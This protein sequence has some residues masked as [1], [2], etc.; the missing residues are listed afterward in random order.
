[1]TR[2]NDA[3]SVGKQ[4]IP[5]IA[6]MQ[7]HSGRMI[8]EESIVY[9]ILDLLNRTQ[10]TLNVS[11]VDQLGR[12][13]L[14]TGFGQLRVATK[15]SQIN[16]QF[17]YNFEISDA[18]IETSGNGEVVIEDSMLVIRNADTGDG[19]ASS[20]SLQALRYIAGSMAVNAFTAAGIPV[21]E[22]FENTKVLIGNFDEE[23]GFA[24]GSIDGVPVL[25]K[26][27]Y[28]G[29]GDVDELIIPQ[30][31]WDDP[32][33]GTGPSGLVYDFF[34][35]NVYEISW[36]YLGFGPIVF[37]ILSPDGQYIPIHTIKYPNSNIRTHIS[38]PYLP[39]RAEI[40]NTGSGVKIEIKI[41]SLDA[42]IYDG[43]GN[44]IARRSRG[45]NLLN[46]PGVL[47]KA[48]DQSGYLV[49]FRG[50]EELSGRKNKIASLLEIVNASTNGAR[51]SVLELIFDPT[52]ITQGTWTRVDG[53]SEAESLTP[54]E[55]SVDTVFDLNSG[56]SS[57]VSFSLG[58]VDKIPPFFLEQLN[59]LLRRGQIALFK[60][61]SPGTATYETF[62]IGY[63]DLY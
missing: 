3:N 17:G 33:D 49:A 60:V 39:V 47:P 20:E 18:I 37:S 34:N 24:Y 56:K 28:N 46:I 51:D 44:D 52:I 22:G 55:Y 19:T 40:D 31:E 59:S 10:D 53:K 25:I 30:S 58:K 9:N 38:L 45:F 57:G 35:G 54:I 13:A 14:S 61:T 7:M 4:S 63:Y 21:G 8:D 43:G 48:I 26:R 29:P 2:R 5:D 36:I 11:I 23:D 50:A 42:A 32:L 15:V 6:Q 1:M 12:P 41:G 16:G 27:R 62:S